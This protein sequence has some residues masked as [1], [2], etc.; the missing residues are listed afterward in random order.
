MYTFYNVLFQV[1]DEALQDEPLELRYH[2]CSKISNRFLL[3][4]SN[5]LLVFRAGIHKILVRIANW[6][7]PDQTA[8][9]EVGRSS[10]LLV[11]IVYVLLFFDRVQNV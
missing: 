5:K 11:C 2:K 7:D 4:F 10:L 1:E 3:P 6:D 8:S 9:L